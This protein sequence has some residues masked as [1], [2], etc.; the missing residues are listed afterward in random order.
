MSAIRQRLCPLCCAC[1]ATGMLLGLA[2]ALHAESTGDSAKL[3]DRARTYADV[4]LEHGRDHW[5]EQSCP[6]FASMLDRENMALMVRADAPGLKP[7]GLRP[8][9]RDYQSANVAHDEE[10]YRLLYE[11]TEVTGDPRYAQAADAALAWFLTNCRSDQTQLLAWGEHIGWNLQRDEVMTH[12][13]DDG[14]YLVDF[15]EFF[16]R[17]SM[18]NKFAQLQP[19]ALVAYAVGLWRYGITD[20]ENLHFSRHARYLSYGGGKDGG[21]GNEFPRYYGHMVLVWA[22]A[23]P[24]VNDSEDRRTLQHAIEHTLKTALSRRDPQTAAIPAGT[25]KPTKIRDV[26]WSGNALMMS[27]DLHEALPLLPPS[28]AKLANELATSNDAVILQLPHEPGRD[29][30]GFVMS[31]DVHT[32]EPGDPRGKA[33]DFYSSRWAT[34]YGNPTTAAVALQFAERAEQVDNADMHRLVLEAADSYL[35][36][37]PDTQYNLHPQALADVIELLLTAY[38]WTDDPRYLDR[39]QAMAGEAVA[40]FLD[41]TSPLPK[42]LLREY[43]HYETLSGGDALMLAMLHV[44]R[45]Q[46][47][48]NAS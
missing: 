27:L 7:F 14:S 6:L 17:W 34:G 36:E 45:A 10:L 28:L 8:N 46:K 39:A 15:H 26:Y 3:F 13:W 11:L 22:Y 40:L 2:T 29:G 12:M 43:D 20:H 23:L 41:D 18:W 47:A 35:T 25:N 9:D 5:G 38:R 24:L 19:K 4:M 33:D 30:R 42:V 32:L 1:L 21:K 48:E 16:G 37:E 44:Y 31:A